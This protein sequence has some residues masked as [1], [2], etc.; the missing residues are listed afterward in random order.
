[1]GRGGCGRRATAGTPAARVLCDAVRGGKSQG[2]RPL[3]VSPLGPRGG[4]EDTGRAGARRRPGQ[5]GP[6][7]R[8][9][10]QGSTTRGRPPPPRRLE[11][12]PVTYPLGRCGLRRGCPGYW[13][14]GLGGGPTSRAGEPGGWGRPTPHVSPSPPLPPASSAPETCAEPGPRRPR[15]RADRLT[16]LQRQ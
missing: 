5:A 4:R 13:P 12:G 6:R 9:R 8:R 3:D 15:G 11:D 7:G 16:A 10:R 2:R 14:P 1:M